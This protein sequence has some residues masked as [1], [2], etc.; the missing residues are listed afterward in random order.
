MSRRRIE[1]QF[2][3]IRMAKDSVRPDEAWVS[4]TREVLRMQVKNGM[5]TV[6]ADVQE[7]MKAFAKVFL[8]QTFIQV[9][10]GPALAVLSIIGLITGGSIAGVSAAEKSVP[11]D[12]LYQVKLANEQ[13]QLLLAKGKPDRLELKAN[14][15]ARRG[16][17]IKDIVSS[18]VSQ[19]QERIKQATEILKRDLD[20]VKTQLNE[21][22]KEESGKR[23][24]E[25][26]KIV[27]QKSTELVTTLKSV[28]PN[29]PQSSKSG[30]LEVESAAVTTGVKAVQVLIE[31][32][33]APG[34]QGIVTK[35]EI[36]NSI[37]QKTEGV[38]ET[39][40]DATEKLLNATASTT[41][42]TLPAA[43]TSTN[44]LTLSAVST[45]LASVSG[46]E[47]LVQS[48][49]QIQ[50]AQTSL[51]E[52]KQLLEDDQLDQASDKLIEAAKAAIVVEKIVEPIVASSST[53]VINPAGSTTGTVSGLSTTSST[54]PAS[55]STSVTGTITT[56]TTL[57]STT[58][59]T[60][61][62]STQR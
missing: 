45:T 35:E 8:P 46:T 58:S 26:A 51:A 42:A 34:A 2:R 25:A 16:Q 43:S 15:I 39:V 40:M 28:K 62:S 9:F 61:S 47:M 4:R 33:D 24:A 27:D 29:L 3:A 23:A 41:L 57:N 5:P 55:S 14:F 30:V 59:S 17:E 49:N 36:I 7:K 13:T 12:F 20:T 31:T 52:T 6:P 21:V 18:D 11:G 37:N 53:A 44:Q 38:Q 19:K 56:S 48:L 60:T 50:T 32:K 22:R 10:R 54:T 1:H